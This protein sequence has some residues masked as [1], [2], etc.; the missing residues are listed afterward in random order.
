MGESAWDDL[1]GLTLLFLNG[2]GGHPVSLT[3]L[4]DYF[5][6]ADYFP[7]TSMIPVEMLSILPVQANEELRPSGVAPGV[8]HRQ[9]AAVVILVVAVQFTIDL[10]AGSSGTRTI[11]ASA[12]YD[13][14]GNDP[15]EGQVI[16]EAVFGQFDEIGYG[17]GGVMVIKFYFQC[18]FVGLNGCF[19]Q[20]SLAFG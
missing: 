17:I 5:E 1:P 13:E 9:N 7:E 3:D 12:L 10:V 6:A 20:N 4:V 11:R 15:V 16:V 18:A 14:S 8:S 2:N 19:G